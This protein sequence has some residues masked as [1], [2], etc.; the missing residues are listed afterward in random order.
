[1]I[2]FPC[3]MGKP[4][5]LD[6]NVFCVSSVFFFILTWAYLISQQENFDSESLITP[7]STASKTRHHSND[8]FLSGSDIPADAPSGVHRVGGAPPTPVRGDGAR[9]GSESSLER[10]LA[11]LNREMEE[12]QVSPLS[13]LESESPGLPLLSCCVT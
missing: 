3:S 8:S 12:I 4:A 1:M 6:S 9:K 2:A 11:I 7:P 10:E 13:Q 5:G